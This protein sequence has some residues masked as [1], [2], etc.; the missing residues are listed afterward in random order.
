MGVLV[1]RVC[2]KYEKVSLDHKIMTIQQKTLNVIT[3][4]QTKLD[5]I[6]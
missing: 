5:N 6:S 4:G 1:K 2:V 3:L